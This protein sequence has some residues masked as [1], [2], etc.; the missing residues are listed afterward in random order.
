MRVVAPQLGLNQLAPHPAV[1]APEQF[2]DNQRARI[3]PYEGGTNG[4]PLKGGQQ[5]AAVL[6]IVPHFAEGNRASLKGVGVY[7]YLGDHGWRTWSVKSGKVRL[8]LV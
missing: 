8:T 4:L 5:N 2:P 3:R 1:Q 6:Q 7:E